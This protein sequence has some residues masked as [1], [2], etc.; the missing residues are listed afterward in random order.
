MLI[1][2]KIIG[3]NIR[4]ARKTIG[5][6]Q[7]QVAHQLGISLLH[8]GRLERGERPASLEQLAAI[9][10]AL[11]TPL[12]QLLSGCCEGETFGVA[13]DEQSKSLGEEVTR[14][15]DGCSDYA[16]ALM[17]SLCRTVAEQDCKSIFKK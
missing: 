9:S 15:A 2:Y 10:I 11:N 4:A 5:L 17:L 1:S 8:Y 6:T 13:P 14:L 12:A 3:R 7:E 16:K